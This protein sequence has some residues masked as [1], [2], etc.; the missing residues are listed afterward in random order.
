MIKKYNVES[1][2]SN[3]VFSSFY[4][5]ATEKNLKSIINNFDPFNDNFR[6]KP[7]DRKN[8]NK[9]LEDKNLKELRKISKNF[10]TSNTMYL[11]LC[12]YLSNIYCYYWMVNP[13]IKNYDIDNNELIEKWWEVLDYIEEINP[14]ITGPYINKKVILEGACYIAI[15]EQ[16]IKNSAFGIQYLPI[17]YCRTTKRYLDRDVVDF[18]VKYF[19]EAFSAKDK[20]D[21]ALESF[22]PC[23]T[24]KYKEWKSMK[25]KSTGSEWMTIDP[26]YAF[27][28]TLRQDE[29]PYFIGIVLDIL[30]AQDIKDITMFK[31][32]QELSKIL[33]QKFGINSE[34]NPIVDLD[35]L[36]SFHRETS[37]MFKSVPGVDVVTTYADIDSVDLQS[38]ASENTQYSPTSKIVD[39]VYDSAGVS[40]LL[41]NANNSSTMAKS[42]VNDESLTITLLRQFNSFLNVRL[43]ANFKKGKVWKTI[44]FNA[45]LLEVTAYNKSDMIK[46][47]KEQTSLG[48][49]KF[50][51][52]IATGQKQ[53]SIM[54]NLY[55]ENEVLNIGSLLRPPATSNT[56]SSSETSQ[57]V[58]RPTAEEGEVSDKTIQ[59]RETL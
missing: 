16:T 21:E 44:D 33:V 35:I 11:R 23:I 22:P 32:E 12:D 46:I 58:G 25:K 45:T 29:V 43:K 1:S 28:F 49:S 42:I 51:P 13:K 47:Y 52:A 9:Y 26:D 6:Q 37:E 50:L 15:R 54:S 4:G 48:F 41:F 31:L 34:G 20:R 19:D 36:K 38:H 7:V 8:F 27:R 18:N 40:K 2:S 57:E 14:E 10:Y 30:D 3:T 24:D 39:N 59:N 17:E 5:G 56:A 53:S 55:F